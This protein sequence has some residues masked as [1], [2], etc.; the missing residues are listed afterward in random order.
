MAEKYVFGPF[1][2]SAGREFKRADLEFYSIDHFRPSFVGRIYFNDPDVDFDTASEDRPSYAGSFAIFGH[3]KCAGDVGHCDL[4]GERRRFDDRPSH[5]LTRAFKRVVVTD[6]LR[7]A[8]DEGEEL[9]ITVVVASAEDGKRKK[10]S[11]KKGKKKEKP[12][13]KRLFD[14]KGMQLVTFD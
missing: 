4:P 13:Y 7:K 8:C 1:A 12:H 11:K 3:E 14:F 6:A 9:T 10:T 2:H 5:P